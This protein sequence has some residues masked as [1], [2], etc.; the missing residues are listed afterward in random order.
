MKRDQVRDRGDAANI[1]GT[2]NLSG[3]PISPWGWVNTWKAPQ[4]S[5]LFPASS[6]Q[7]D[8]PLPGAARGREQGAEGKYR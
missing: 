1:F 3:T 8:L 4:G 6:L 5:V 7:W 2:F